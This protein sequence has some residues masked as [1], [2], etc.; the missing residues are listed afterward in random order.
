L[1]KYETVNEV[2]DHLQRLFTQSNFTKQYQLENDIRA[3]HHK[4]VRIQE[5]YSAM[6]YLWDQL[7]FTESV[8]LKAWNAY[9]DHREQQWLIQFLTTL[10]NDFEGLRSSIKI[11]IFITQIIIL[12]N[13]RI[14]TTQIIIFFILKLW[15]ITKIIISQHK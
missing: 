1:A 11:K 12:R 8:K 10:R 6:T 3:F 7:A 2:W 9:I 5:F 14:F 15:I 13:P 4:N